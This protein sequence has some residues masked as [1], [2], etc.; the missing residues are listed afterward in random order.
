MT[1]GVFKTDFYLI[2]S[3][4]CLCWLYNALYFP[5]GL[6][7]LGK[8]SVVACVYVLLLCFLR[9]FPDENSIYAVITLV[10]LVGI[11]CYLQIVFASKYYLIVTL[12]VLVAY[13]VQTYIGYLQA[14]ENNAE[15]LS[16]KGA[17]YNSGIFANYLA[18]LIPLFLFGSMNKR[19][20]KLYIRIVFLSVFIAA[21]VLLSLT[22][23]RAALI[24]SALGCLFVMFSFT[25]KSIIKRIAFVF[26]T[27]IPIFIFAGIKLYKLKPASALGRL[28]IYKVSIN[29]IKD[30]PLLGVG[31]NRFSAV[32]NNYQASY[33]KNKHTS[34]ETQLLANDIL[35]AYNS[36]TQILVEYGMIGIL[37][38]I[39][40]AYLLIKRVGTQREVDSYLLLRKG[41]IGCIIS[42]IISSF[43]S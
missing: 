26:I 6:N 43:F 1:T 22:M 27:S 19:E 29:V 17:L 33:F 36:L 34:V 3:T 15:S 42:I 9:S 31:P 32:Y 37:F 28:T 18:G 40:F 12:A 41:H 30:Y 11:V 10:C 24:G 16:I 20:L 38:L 2:W 39:C 5:T 25:R 21:I 4:G 13:F 23:A 7:R 14:F 8:V 35:E